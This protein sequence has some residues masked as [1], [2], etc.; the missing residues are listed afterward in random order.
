MTDI[1]VRNDQFSINI[2]SGRLDVF[3]SRMARILTAWIVIVTF[4]SFITVPWLK[5][6]SNG[7]LTPAMIW[8]YHAIMLPASLLFLILCT[9]VFVTHNWVR[10]L[11]SHSALVAIFEGAGFL[12]LGYGN[13]HHISSLISF[14]YWVIMPCTLEL[15]AITVIFV[16]D[17]AYGA[18]RPPLGESVSPQKA[19]IRWAVFFAGISV[20]TWVVLGLLAA[21]SQVG[22]SWSFWASWQ[23]ESNSALMGNIITS[24]SH[25]MLPSFM[26]GIVFLAAEA[27]GYSALAGIRKQAARIGVAIM[28]G[29]IAL[30][31]GIYAIS[32]IGTFAIPAWF[33]SGAGGANGIAMDDSLTGLVGLGALVLAFSMLPEIR[34]SFRNAGN[35]IKK[36]FNPVRLAVYMTYVMACAA[37]F[38]YGY[39][40]EMNESRYGFASTSSATSVVNDQ[41]FT[42]AHLLLVFGSLPVI[43]VFLL[44]AELLSDTSGIGAKLKNL[45]SASILVGM[46]LATIGLGVW[47]FSAPGHGQTLDTG[48][49]GA[50]LYVVGQCLILFGGFIQ[51]FTMHSPE[52]EESTV[53]R[54]Y[55]VV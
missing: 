31:S 28:L 10:Y 49:A 54:Q 41:I 29:G 46:V 17:L 24:H 36:H 23:H 27:F 20:L 33:P 52:L 19:E 47:T 39:F 53:I 26:A 55:Q 50:I 21:A 43:A 11:I 45:M 4:L 7:D 22:I 5:D 51:L 13:L 48:N 8:F 44:A 34:G 6:A 32:A 2:P 12:V 30:Y 16:L 15:F 14:G 18:F 40:I 25:G 9:R 1:S 37:M 35:S 42:R 3:S 38:V